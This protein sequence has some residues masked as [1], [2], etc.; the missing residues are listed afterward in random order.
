MGDDCRWRRPLT[1]GEQ[2]CGMTRLFRLLEPVLYRN[3]VTWT[4]PIRPHKTALTYKIKIRYTLGSSPRIWVISPPMIA[5]ERGEIP[6]LYADGSLCLHLPSEWNP[7]Q[8]VA[9]TVVPWVSDW[10]VHYEIW[11]ATENWEGGGVHPRP[12]HRKSKQ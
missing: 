6:H 8:L 1:I 7:R 3:S 5:N 10:L 12:S 2:I 9:T 11:R 4:G